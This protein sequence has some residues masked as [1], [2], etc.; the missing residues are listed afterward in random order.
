MVFDGEELLEFAVKAIRKEIDFICV[1]YQTTSYFGN[2]GDPEIHE[3]MRRLKDQG[4]IDQYI[5]Y[6]PDLT[7]TPKENELI[8]RNIGLEASKNNGCTH[9]ISADVDEFY[10]SNQL[11]YAKENIGNSDFSVA[12]LQGYYKDPTY[13]IVPVQK[14][15]VTF[16]HPV[17]NCY[18]YN[19]NFPF[20]IE[21]TRRLE[22]FK[23]YRVFNSNEMII[24]H[25]SY[26]RKD[27][28]KKLLNSDNGKFYT[29]FEKFIQD[30]NDYQLGD[31]L[32]IVPDFINR[33]T[34]QVENQFNIK[35]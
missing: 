15:L 16:I 2:N 28:R 23:E 14:L 17:E 7:L 5:Y 31:R 9:H 27:I 26:V 24:H 11:V 13:L 32:K 18:V 35:F 21:I 30:F 1:T 20:K 4:F 33:R 10:N 22:K 8:L 12:P 19:K 29:K 3:L 25:M 6:E 34:V